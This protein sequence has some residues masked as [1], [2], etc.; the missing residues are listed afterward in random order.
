M[1]QGENRTKTTFKNFLPL[2]YRKTIS[3]VVKKKVLACIEG[4]AKVINSTGKK[5]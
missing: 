2:K 1:K 5:L 4:G 3:Y